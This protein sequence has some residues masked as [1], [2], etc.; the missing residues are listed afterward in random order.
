MGST[1]KVDE[2]IALQQSQPA[3]RLLAPCLLD[4][5]LEPWGETELV[6]EHNRTPNLPD[7]YDLAI[8]N[9]EVGEHVPLHLLVGR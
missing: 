3:S 4:Y 7:V 1:F 6:Q 5:L 9:L 2:A 8:D